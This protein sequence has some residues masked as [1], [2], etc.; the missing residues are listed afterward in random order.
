MNVSYIPENV[1]RA[2]VKTWMGPT[3]VFVHLDTVSKM[4]S[5]KVRG[6]SVVGNEQYW[7]PH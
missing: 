5:V 1:H 4:T 3:D 6:P 7:L 2:P